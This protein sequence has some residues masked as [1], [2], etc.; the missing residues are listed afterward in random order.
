MNKARMMSPPDK[1]QRWSFIE[2]RIL[3]GTGAESNVEVILN[4][5]L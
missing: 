2:S 5:D 1:L 4:G 3:T